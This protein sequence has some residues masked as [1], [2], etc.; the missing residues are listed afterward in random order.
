MTIHEAKP[1]ST[2]ASPPCEDIA[3]E[4]H[5][6]LKLLLILLFT[7][8]AASWAYCSLGQP[9]SIESSLDMSTMPA[10]ETAP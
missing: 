3:C 4:P 5:Y 9:A 2:L 7:G 8:V 10:A 6:L 1:G